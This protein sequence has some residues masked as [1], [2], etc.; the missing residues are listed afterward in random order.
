MCRYSVHRRR[1]QPQDR[2]RG[3]RVSSLSDQFSFQLL[4][5]RFNI[6]ALQHEQLHIECRTL[7]GAP[8]TQ[9]QVVAADLDVARTFIDDQPTAVDVAGGRLSSS[10]IQCDAQWCATTSR[11]DRSRSV[12][13]TKHQA[14]RSCCDGR[15]RPGAVP[16]GPGSAAAIPSAE[17]AP[18][19]DGAAPV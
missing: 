2:R 1:D 8:D 7:A 6:P 17:A 5:R 15:V 14:G 18:G 9:R 13:H 3:G 11:F 12:R 10:S 19:A 4:S 16:R